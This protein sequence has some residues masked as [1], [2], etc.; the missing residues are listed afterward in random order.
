MSL[1]HVFDMDGT[2]INGTSAAVQVARTCGTEAE[3]LDLERAFSAGE[4]TTK[5]FSATL[6][7]LWSELTEDHI[8]EAFAAC[9]FLD[10]I[11][12]VCA[13]IRARGES[14]LVVTMSADFFARRMLGFGFDDVA[15]SRFPPLPFSR[16]LDP[17][18]V[19]V[20]EDKVRIVEE[21]RERT[22]IPLERCVAYGD[23]MSDAPLF[24]HLPHSVAVNSDH[25]LAGIA[26]AEY[27]GPSLM[28]AYTR[29]RALLQEAA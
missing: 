16:P 3:L 2:L 22:G 7:A 5:A 4:I 13:D 28:D 24:R 15:A 14:S 1:L 23:S 10:E 6:H 8:D 25:H 26:R 9:P 19:L 20:P 12:E 17:A 29:G 18:A 11:S 27:R 21:A